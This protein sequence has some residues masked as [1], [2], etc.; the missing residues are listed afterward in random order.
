MSEVVAVRDWR[1]FS[2]LM[3]RALVRAVL[4]GM[5]GCGFAACRRALYEHG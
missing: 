5:A 2:L 1:I 4:K 3:P